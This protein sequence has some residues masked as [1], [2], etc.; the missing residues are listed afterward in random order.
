MLQ[1]IQRGSVSDTGFSTPEMSYED[2]SYLSGVMEDRRRKASRKKRL[3]SSLSLTNF[4]DIYSLRGDV[5]GEGSTG[6]VLTGLNLFTGQ[7]VAVKVI[8]KT[9]SWFFSRDKVLREIELYYSCR[10]VPEIV[11]LLEYFE[12]EDAFY[13]IFEKAAGGPLF[14]HLGK[15]V[16]SSE[17][18]EIIK[19]LSKALSFLHKKGVA[20]RDLK[21]ENILC[22]SKDSP[23][24]VKLCDFDLCSSVL[25]SVST[26]RLRSPVGSA[27]YMAPEVVKAF[28]RSS[29]D[30][31]IFL[32]DEYEEDDFSYDKRCDLWS[33]GVLIYILNTG[34]MPFRG[35]CEQGQA[36]PWNTGGECLTCQR[37]LFR[38]IVSGRIDF[39]HDGEGDN[40]INAPISKEAKDL[41]LSLLSL[42]PEERLSAEEVAEHPWVK[43]VHKKKKSFSQGSN[44][45]SLFQTNESDYHQHKS[46]L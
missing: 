31:D 15:G 27:E 24:P 41:I 42:D 30:L 43:S 20:H 3:M 16:T 25:P 9:E 22:V 2:S 7:E 28:I 34:V 11:Q 17:A 21:P 40:A 32:E 5:L 23:Y 26:P 44:A 10:G 35:T 4:R 29:Y 14:D 36:C 45:S 6:R 33:L 12:E 13:L 46:K 1:V 8:S 18:K 19:D 37:T 39:P 38:S